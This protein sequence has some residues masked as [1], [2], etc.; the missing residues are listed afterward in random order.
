MII[1]YLVQA[2][3]FP[4]CIVRWRR[5]VRSENSYLQARPFLPQNYLG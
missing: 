1:Q 2:V 5:L 3:T 4:L